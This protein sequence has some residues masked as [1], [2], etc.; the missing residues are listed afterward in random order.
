M[1]S[2]LSIPNLIGLD[3]NSEVIQ[4]NKRTSKKES[5]WIVTNLAYFA[6]QKQAR[7]ITNKK[8]D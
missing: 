2:L 6:T 7:K 4:V 3:L 1:L 5:K 8:N